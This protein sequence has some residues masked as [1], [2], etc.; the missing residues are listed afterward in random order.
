MLDKA[1][2]GKPRALTEH[3]RNSLRRFIG[4]NKL[5]RLALN[6]I[7]E[8]LTEADMGS[9]KVGRSVCARVVCVRVCAGVV[10]LAPSS[11]GARVVVVV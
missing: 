8:Q 1:N 5:K 9:L 2:G 4:M 10:G 11:S 6:V 7:A 3:L